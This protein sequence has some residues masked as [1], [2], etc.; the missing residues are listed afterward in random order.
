R[1]QGETDAPFH[2]CT[3]HVGIDGHAAI[4]GADHALDLDLA[5]AHRHFGHLR[6]VRVER[7]VHGDALRNAAASSSII[8]S[9]TYA[10]CVLPTERHQSGRTASV[11]ECSDPASI[12]RS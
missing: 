10:V 3:D 5:I 9:I 12:G 8:V 2:L 4:D 1:A 11:G 6:D 7:L